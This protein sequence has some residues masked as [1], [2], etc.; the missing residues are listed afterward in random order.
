[1]LSYSSS[2]RGWSETL[3]S[4]GEP[5]AGSKPGGSLLRDQHPGYATGVRSRSEWQTLIQRGVKVGKG[6][7]S[8]PHSHLILT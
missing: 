2:I 4:E 6:I 5:A 1:M 3:R 8:R 7:F